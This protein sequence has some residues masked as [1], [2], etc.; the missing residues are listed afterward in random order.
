M[1]KSSL[2]LFLLTA[3]LWS[4]GG[5]SEKSA[6]ENESSV[7]SAMI[8]SEQLFTT[9]CS[10][11]HGAQMQAFVD[12]KWKF[13][14][15]TDSLYSTITKGR[16]TEVGAMPSFKAGFS[17]DQLSE[18]IAY[19]QYGIENVDKYKFQEETVTSNKFKTEDFSYTADT[20][21]TGLVDVWGLAFLPDGNI[22]VTDKV[23]DMYLANANGEKTKIENAPTVKYAGQGGLLDVEIDPNYD[24]NP[25]IYISYSRIKVE[26]NDTLTASAVSRYKLEGNKLTNE[27][28]IFEALP[29]SKRFW[30]YGCRLE[31]D[32]EGYLFVSVGD[33]GDRDVNPQSLSVFHGKVHRINS[34]GTI[35][36]DNPFTDNPD[37]AQSIYSYGHRNPQGLAYNAQTNQL[38]EHEHGP[39]GGDEINIIEPGTNYGWPVISYGLNY[40]GTTFTNITAKDGMSQPLHYWTPS[41]APCGMDFV[42]SDKYP[43]WKNQL[44]VGS[45]RFRYINLCKIEDGKVASEEILMKNMGRVRVVR[46]AP[47]GFIYVGTEEPG[48]VY[49]L[50]PAD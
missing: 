34:D 39:R 31:F 44:L 37:A 10:G 28:L 36:A 5:N 21:L 47:D 30:H 38:W 16:N 15:S 13:G 29:Y 50:V 22:L 26:A 41:I 9:Y 1:L 11:C 14:N 40:D 46:Q 23:G 27:E 18:L 12:R 45:L 48:A 42:T 7:D 6:N 19:I 17:E 35:P 24:E 3:C 43:G 49:R 2:P 8:R 33:R 20:I 32:R 4:C 25:W